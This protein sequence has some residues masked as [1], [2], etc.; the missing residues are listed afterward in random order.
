MLISVSICNKLWWIGVSRA[1][2]VVRVDLDEEAFEDLRSIKEFL[3]LKNYSEV[4]RYLIGEKAREIRELEKR[5]AVTAVTSEE[6][7]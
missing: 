6:A 1:R 5:E 3:R 7:G 2:F 4:I